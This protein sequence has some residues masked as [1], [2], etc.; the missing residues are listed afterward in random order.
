MIDRDTPN[1]EL[2]SKLHGLYTDCEL[3]KTHLLKQIR[4]YLEKHFPEE[5]E[6]F[7]K[8]SYVEVIDFQYS[9]FSDILRNRFLIVLRSKE[10]LSKVEIDAFCNEFDLIL[11]KVN[12]EST[13]FRYDS[14]GLDKSIFGDPNKAFI[15]YSFTRKESI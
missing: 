2:L 7:M 13:L 1:N 3:M 6:Y 15:V 14:N 10:L 11:K 12:I 9:T 8:S 4:K 5:G